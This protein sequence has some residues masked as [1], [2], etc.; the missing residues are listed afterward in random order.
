MH[1]L[2]VVQDEEADNSSSFLGLQWDQREKCHDNM[3]QERA[4]V[5]WLHTLYKTL[6]GPVHTG[7]RNWHTDLGVWA[8]HRVIP[9]VSL[10]CNNWINKYI[11]RGLYLISKFM[12]SE[13]ECLYWLA[14]EQW[15]VFSVPQA[16]A[17]R[18]H[19]LDSDW[20]DVFGA[21][22]S[23]QSHHTGQYL[24]ARQRWCLTSWPGTQGTKDSK[25]NQRPCQSILGFLPVN[26]NL[27]S[28][29]IHM[30]SSI[31]CRL[32]LT[33]QLLAV[34][35]SC[36]GAEQ[37]HVEKGKNAQQLWL[38]VVCLSHRAENSF[39]LKRR[40]N[41]CWSTK[42]MCV[43]VS[44]VK[45][46]LKETTYHAL[47]GGN[48]SGTLVRIIIGGKGSQDCQP[49]EDLQTNP[50][51]RQ[52]VNSLLTCFGTHKWEPEGELV[53][54]LVVLSQPQQQL[55]VKTLE[56]LSE[57][58][59]QFNLR[60]ALLE[61]EEKPTCTSLSNWF[62]WTSAPLLIS[63]T[64]GT[65]SPAKCSHIWLILFEFLAKLI[66]HFLQRLPWPQRGDSTAPNDEWWHIKVGN[67]D[68]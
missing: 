42:C 47:L 34:F 58:R 24:Q 32:L 67:N 20:T 19:H 56:V 28:N 43:Q 10:W 3:T 48:V 65:H 5:C 31:C 57:Q 13:C 2:P 46:H 39:K 8:N 9:T 60:L 15:E 50:I 68:S 44:R 17:E 41:V 26:S 30:F 52:A 29:R 64:A 16:C 49:I 36:A 35:L 54:L 12:T 55:V 45:K 14:A 18:R 66:I 53:D 25:R 7:R 61:H 33:Y 23:H 21:H 11:N 6:P 40:G 38:Q 59:A 37:L 27:V 4:E 62:F 22:Q 1:T 51:V 63:H